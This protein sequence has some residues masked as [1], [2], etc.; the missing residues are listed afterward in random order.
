LGK[1]LGKSAEI[2]VPFQP[3]QKG[4]GGAGAH[5][6]SCLTSLPARRFFLASREALDAEHELA[7]HVTTTVRERCGRGSSS[8][9][10]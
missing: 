7:V 2:P 1:H 10:S 6:L 3:R 5:P 4:E 9:R 8:G